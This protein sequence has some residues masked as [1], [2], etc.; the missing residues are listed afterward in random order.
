MTPNAADTVW[1]GLGEGAIVTLPFTV[2]ADDMDAFARLS[3]DANPMHT[4]DAFARNAG[5]DGPVVFGGLMVAWISQL[6]GMHLP[7]PGALWSGLKIDFRNPLYVGEAAELTGEITHCSEATKMVTL[8]IQIMA[9][10][11]KIATATAEAV[12]KTDG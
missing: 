2:S 9:S 11:R 12:V 6:I 3:G 4:D 1:E 5:L 7:G 8:K 10:Y